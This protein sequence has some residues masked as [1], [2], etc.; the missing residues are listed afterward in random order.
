MDLVTSCYM[1]SYLAALARYGLHAPVSYTHLDVYKRQLLTRYYTTPTV[2]QARDS[3]FWSLLFI[4]LLYMTAPAYA[5]F[6][7][8]EVLSHLAEIPIAKLPGWVAAWSRLGLISIEDINHD[9]ILQLAEL[10]LNPD[11]IVLATPEIA[12]MPYVCLL[13]TSRCV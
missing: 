13:Y 3:V 8:Y 6:A 1:E 9:G 2:S 12:G 10:S 5:V 4:L 7:K 11:V